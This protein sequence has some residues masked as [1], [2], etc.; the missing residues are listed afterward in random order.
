MSNFKNLM[1]D[2]KVTLKCG[3]EVDFTTKLDDPI[4]FVGTFERLLVCWQSTNEDVREA[5]FEEIQKRAIEYAHKALAG[6][7][8]RA[9][10]AD[11]AV[12]LL[13][14]KLVNKIAEE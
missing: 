14:V 13:I 8:M 6:Y 1:N 7:N 4:Q 10:M 12:K 9:R 5:A 11:E 3:C 2:L